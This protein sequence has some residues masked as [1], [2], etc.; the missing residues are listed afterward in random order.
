[1][2]FGQKQ[3]KIDQTMVNLESI[4]ETISQRPREITTDNLLPN[5]PTIEDL[6]PA[7]DA[8]TTASN[9]PQMAAAQGNMNLAP[10]DDKIL[11]DIFNTRIK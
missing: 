9:I 5:L 2:A 1:M 8:T 11:T 4:G 10:D 6:G 3:Q 7:L